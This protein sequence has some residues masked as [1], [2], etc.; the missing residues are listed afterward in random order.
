MSQALAAICICRACRVFHKLCP[1][2]IPTEPTSLHLPTS[3][4]A[5]SGVPDRCGIGL[6]KGVTLGHHGDVLAQDLHLFPN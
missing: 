4:T 1:A 6:G 5:C 2:G 3:K